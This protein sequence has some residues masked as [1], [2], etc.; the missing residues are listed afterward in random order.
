MASSGV[1]KKS[2]GNDQSC[3]EGEG[4]DRVPSPVCSD[5]GPVN[6]K[7][8]EF[9]GKRVKHTRLGKLRVTDIDIPAVRRED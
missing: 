4:R 8:Y 7:D 6:S 1:R 5:T 9:T 2:G 3:F